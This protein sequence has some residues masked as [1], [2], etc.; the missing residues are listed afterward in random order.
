MSVIAWDGQSVAADKQLTCG[1]TTMAITKVHKLPTGEIIG[2]VGCLERGEELMNW[3]RNGAKPEEFPKFGDS[4]G[5]AELI[6]VTEESVSSYVRSP[7]SAPIENSFM[8]WGSGGDVALGA[9]AMG[10]TAEEAVEI[11]C[12]FNSACGLGINVLEVGGV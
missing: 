10:A 12:R 1:T 9:M 11:A 7:Y 5:D 6:V 2:L 4:V 3:Y 8:A